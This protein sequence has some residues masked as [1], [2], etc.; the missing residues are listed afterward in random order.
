MKF[1][2]NNGYAQKLATIVLQIAKALVSKYCKT[3]LR[4]TASNTVID[5]L[6]KAFPKQIHQLIVNGIRVLRKIKDN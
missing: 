3:H 1:W 4:V 2:E 6:Y 5:P